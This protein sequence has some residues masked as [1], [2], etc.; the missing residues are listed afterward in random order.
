MIHVRVN[1]HKGKFFVVA[2]ADHQKDL[3][4]LR[5]MS[6]ALFKK[7]KINLNKEEWGGPYLKIDCD[8]YQNTDGSFNVNAI[9]DF[10][11]TLTTQYN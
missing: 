2:I 10:A 3:N 9:Q 6:Y 11:H 7:D 5:L 1:E 4:N 8:S